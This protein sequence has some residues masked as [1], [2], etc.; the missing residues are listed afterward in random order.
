[1]R[2]Q[3]LTLVS[4]ILLFVL[5]AA[6]AAAGTTFTAKGVKVVE[7]WVVGQTDMKLSEAPGNITDEPQNQTRFGYLDSEEAF[8]KL[9]KAWRKDE[10]PKVD[11]T[12]NLVLVLTHPENAKV[13]FAAVLDDKGE[14]KVSAAGSE[15]MPNGMTYVIAVVERAGIKTINGKALKGEKTD[16]ALQDKL[17]KA[18]VVVVGKVTQTGL[19][20]ASSF[21]VGAIEVREV[22]K[23]NEAIKSVHIRIPSRGDSDAAKYGKKD[24]EGVWIL[25][26]EGGYMAAREVLSYQPLT[27]LDAVK[28]LLPKK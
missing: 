7:K 21:D 4:A 23:G 16:N 2:R 20:T 12:K 19:S 5:G 14:L 18:D 13:E 25:G 8:A 27:E 6:P 1:M 22:L 15:R 17:E 28:K 26:K 9:W 11:F 10:P 3:L 24:V